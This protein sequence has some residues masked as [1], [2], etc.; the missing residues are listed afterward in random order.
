M[1]DGKLFLDSTSEIIIWKP[2]CEVDNCRRV[3]SVSGSGGLRRRIYVKKVEYH[4]CNRCAN[5]PRV[6]LQDGQL[7]LRPAG[8]NSL[9]SKMMNKNE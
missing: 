5:S 4:V 3:L 6:G 8:P 1:R 9:L 7:V 2:V